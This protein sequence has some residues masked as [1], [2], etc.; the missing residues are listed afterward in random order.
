VTKEEESPQEDRLKDHFLDFAPAL[1]FF[2]D[3]EPF[4]FAAIF[5]YIIMKSYLSFL[6]QFLYRVYYTI[7]ILVLIFLYC[8]SL[9]DLQ[10]SQHPSLYR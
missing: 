2:A 8:I 9:L 3:F 10:I 1:T 4:F 5:I 6:I 7:V